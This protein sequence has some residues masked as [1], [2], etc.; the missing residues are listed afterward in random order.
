MRHSNWNVNNFQHHHHRHRSDTTSLSLSSSDGHLA[1]SALPTGNQFRTNWTYGL[2]SCSD[3][4]SRSSSVETRSNLPNPVH[5]HMASG[6][7]AKIPLNIRHN[8][9]DY[10]TGSSS[11]MSVTTISGNYQRQL[12]ALPSITTSD[13]TSEG[14]SD[15]LSVIPSV[16]A[17][18]LCPSNVQ[19]NPEKV[20]T[21][22]RTAS[23][24]FSPK[25]SLDKLHRRQ[26]VHENV[27]PKRRFGRFAR[28]LDFIKSKIDSSSTS[29]LFPS[30]DQVMQWRDSFECL[31]SHKYGC[32]LFRTFLKG[33]FSEE[34]VDFWIECEEFRKMKEGKKATMQKA[35]SIYNKY[36]AEQSPKEVNLDSDTRAATQAALVNGAKPNM[37]SLA[38]T[39][40]E[41]LM[42]KDSYRRFL[43]SKL[44]LDLLC[45]GNSSIS[46]SNKT[47]H[48]ENDCAH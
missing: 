6:S 17:K 35:H 40:I 23:F 33:E 41:Q 13:I 34:N 14:S 39:K 42:A 30:R 15:I 1:S 45:S 24:T 36:I 19:N 27:E 4:C 37:F 2:K 46:N 22:R 3:E 11:N 26:Q 47:L 9:L 21:I 18:Y 28:T 10:T 7:T 29:T 20:G 25:A 43:K 38:Q 48:E 12:T 5:V 16:N 44:F 31:L 32:L 8:D